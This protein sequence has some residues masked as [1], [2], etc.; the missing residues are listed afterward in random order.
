MWQSWN[1]LLGFLIFFVCWSSI[2]KDPNSFRS[3]FVPWCYS[4]PYINFWNC[5]QIHVR[6]FGSLKKTWFLSGRMCALIHSAVGKMKL[7][8]HISV[9][10]EYLWSIIKFLDNH[11]LISITISKFWV[12]KRHLVKVQDLIVFTKFGS[13]LRNILSCWQHENIKIS[14]GTAGCYS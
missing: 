10:I 3:C 5:S 14:F 2:L 6:F 12:S 1:T 11:Y 8:P 9:I 7:H 13:T 4:L